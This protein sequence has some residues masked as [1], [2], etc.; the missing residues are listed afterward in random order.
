MKVPA[1]LEAKVT[2]P[3]GFDP[4][5]VAV[6]VTEVPTVTL[7]GVHVTAVALVAAGKISP[8]LGFPRPTWN[9]SAVLVT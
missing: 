4:V 9:P 2:V 1:V 7:A 3:V 5:T 6:H 8:K